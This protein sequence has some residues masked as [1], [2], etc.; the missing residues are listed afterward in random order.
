MAAGIWLVS[1]TA[2]TPEARA[3]KISVIPD[4]SLVP[5]MGSGLVVYAMEL[6]DEA[7][8]IY[9]WDGGIP[10]NP[11][12]PFNYLLTFHIAGLTN[13]YAEPAIS[14]RDGRVSKRMRWCDCSSFRSRKTP[15]PRGTIGCSSPPIS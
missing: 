13:E 7:T 12:S 5:G 10:Q 8:D 2:S 15:S 14:I 1:N 11:R 4:C 9:I 6:L 3:A